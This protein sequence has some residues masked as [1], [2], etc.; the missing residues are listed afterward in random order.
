L[1][2]CLSSCKKDKLLTDGNA[3]VDFSTDSLLFDTVFTTIGSATKNIRVINNHKQKIRISSIGMEKGASS[4]FILNVDG[5]PGKTFTEIDIPANDSIFI[6]IQVNVN[7]TN[8]NSP[9]IISDKIIFIVNGN[10]QNVYLEAWGQDAYYHKPNNAIKFAHG[11]YLPYSTICDN[12]TTGAAISNTTITWAN[13]KPHVIY[14]WLVVDSTQNLIINAGV[15]VYLHNKAG[16][17]VY[18]GGNLKVNGVKDNE[19]VFQGDRLE[20]EYSDVPGQ[21]DRI[22]IN[23]GSVNNEINYAI[24]KNSYIGIQAE[25]LNNTLGL[26]KNRLRL[27][28]TKIYNVNKWGLY[29]FAFNIYGYN[30]VIVNCKE[31]CAA[32]AGGGNYTFLH[33]TFANFWDKDSRTISCFHVDNHI[34]NFIAPLDTCYFGN[35]IMD[36]SLSGELEIDTLHSAA[37]PPKLKF[38]YSAIRSSSFTNDNK[39]FIGCVPFS[40]SSYVHKVNYNFALTSGNS[41]INFPGPGAASVDALKVGNDITGL[42][43]HNADGL[44]DAGA[45]EK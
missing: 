36:G 43:S 1:I 42:I 20:P 34:G 18:V 31:Y 17:W 25:Y 32:F 8:Q 5:S 28:N 6:F 7:P 22:W 15:K 23:E 35:C 39:Y 16:L 4:Q 9:L 45:Y 26:V 3:K 10:T 24:I 30:N 11:G 44:P 21:W 27:T 13:D 38:S 2:S 37:Y 41:A 19:V 29:A 12:P 33:S 40:N 14:G